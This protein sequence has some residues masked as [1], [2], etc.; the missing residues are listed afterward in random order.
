MGWIIALGVL[1]GLS[2]LP[3]GIRVRYDES[4]LRIVCNIGAIRFLLYPGK[5][6]KERSRKEKADTGKAQTAK[7][8]PK[9]GGDFAQFRE[10]LRI[11]LD[12]LGDLRRKL[13]VKTLEMRLVMAGDD[14]CDLA[15]NYGR[16]WAALGALKPWLAKAFTIRRQD[17]RIECDFTAEKTVFFARA[18]ISVT[19]GR[20]LCL[21]IRYGIRF[22]RQNMK[23][24][25]N[26]RKGGAKT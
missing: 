16:A 3:I 18:H 14:P 19:L 9:R 24:T 12:F 13:R 8:K 10:L 4:G 15:C 20:A 6:R 11:V 22:L 23:T 5:K 7:P 21:A 17:V 2:I 26:K 25:T 1:A